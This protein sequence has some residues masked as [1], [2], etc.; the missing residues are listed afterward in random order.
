MA[1]SQCHNSVL[2][3]VKKTKEKINSRSIIALNIIIQNLSI[4]VL[5]TV[6]HAQIHA[7]GI[8]IAWLL[9]KMYDNNNIKLA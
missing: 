4:M 7:C 8:A 6:I 2:H 1:A 5:N 3:L 9:A